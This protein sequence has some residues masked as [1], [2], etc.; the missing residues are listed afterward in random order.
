LFAW[1]CAGIVAA[2]VGFFLGRGVPGLLS[3]YQTSMPMRLF[4]G[5]VSVGVFLV[6]AIALGFLTLLFGLAWSFGSR[7]FGE[8]RLPTWFAMPANYYRDAFWIG[9]GGSALLIGVRRTLD[10]VSAWWPTAHRG[11]PANFG[12]FFDA[13]FPAAGLIGGTLFHGLFA[14]TVLAL[15]AAFIGAELRARWLRLLL[16]FAVAASLVF[17][18]GSAADFLKQ[19][20]AG[21]LLLAAVVFGIRRMVRFNI[22]GLFLIAA[23]TALLGGAA[24]LLGQPNAFYRRN[25][26]LLLFA[27]IVLL[28][29]PLFM[30]RL[31]GNAA[32]P[33]QD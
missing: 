15:G 5:T 28:A 9:L 25:G 13:I 16:F 29:W 27:I 23:C 1:G 10:F 21:V 3:S 7:A 8:E 14:V 12:S 11:Y 2:A 33:A 32:Q 22:L 17:N 4:L 31:R 19:F 6:G 30:W 26:Y 24:E 20:L 18:W